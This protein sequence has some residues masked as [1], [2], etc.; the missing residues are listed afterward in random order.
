LDFVLLAAR[1]IVAVVF[2]AAGVAKLADRTGTRRGIAGFGVPPALVNPVAII[3][4]LGALID[5]AGRIA[6]Q[7]WTGATP[8][9]ELAGWVPRGLESPTA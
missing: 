8:T 2:V 7:P 3:L 6:S 1:V 9:Q 5:A 4:P